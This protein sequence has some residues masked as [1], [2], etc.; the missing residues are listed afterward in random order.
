LLWKHYDAFDDAG[1]RFVFGIA[2][3]CMLGVIIVVM[4]VV[5]LLGSEIMFNGLSGLPGMG[6]PMPD[7]TI[8][9]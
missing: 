5:V 8:S 9:Q 2:H 7:T 6:T 3:F 1:T 4:A